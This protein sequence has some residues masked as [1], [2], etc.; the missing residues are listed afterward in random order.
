MAKYQVP[1]FIQEEGK[2]IFFLTFRQFFIL[3]G[4]GAVS[5]TLYY[6]LPLS[7]SVVCSIIIMGFVSVI[8]F[9]KINS[10]SIVKF[11]LHFIKFSI[12]EKNYTWQK[13]ESMPHMITADDQ[14]IE[15]PMP[16]APSTSKFQQG[17]LK[18]IK[19][20]IEIKK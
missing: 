12:K 16:Q 9:L 4:G 7:V 6:T 11:V 10:E 5:F 18:A 19:Q 20:M 8:A 17:K 15:P 3:V 2:I 1:Q 14:K 13:K